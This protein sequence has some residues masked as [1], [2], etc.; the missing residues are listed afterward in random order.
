MEPSTED[1]EKLEDYDRLI[2][3]DTDEDLIT[4]H[5]ADAAD[6]ALDEISTYPCPDFT[7]TSVKRF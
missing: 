2:A 3:A 6:S 5:D 4:P 7:I 1:H